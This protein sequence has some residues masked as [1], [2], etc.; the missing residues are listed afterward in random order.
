MS[1]IIKI[2]STIFSE[3]VICPE[4]KGNQC[5]VIDTKIVVTC[6]TCNGAGI[7]KKTTK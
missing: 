2:F 7:I 6:P 5:I 3:A 4:C 1:N